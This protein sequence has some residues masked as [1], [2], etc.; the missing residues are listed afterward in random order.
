MEEVPRT[1]VKRVFSAIASWFR[2]VPPRIDNVDGDGT[3]PTRSLGVCKEWI[4]TV[5]PHS[6]TQHSDGDE[7]GGAMVGRDALGNTIEVRV[8]KEAEHAKILDLPEL[9]QT[10]LDIVVTQ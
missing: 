3:V 1:G 7:S 10:V 9:I 4:D 8:F 5:D 6:I 2:K